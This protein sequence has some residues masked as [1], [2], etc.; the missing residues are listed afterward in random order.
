M[1]SDRDMDIVT[2]FIMGVVALA[3]LQVII[4]TVY[5]LIPNA[6]V[7]QAEI[8]CPFGSELSVIRTTDAK[9]IATCILEP[10]P[11]VETHAASTK[12]YIQK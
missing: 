3:I 2:A 7:R 1:Y 8:D 9:Y 5:W 4:G 6:P 10:I 12:P 11:K